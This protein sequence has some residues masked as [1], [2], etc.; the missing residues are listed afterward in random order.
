MFKNV[1]WPKALSITSLISMVVT[2]VVNFI[3]QKVS[4][5]NE[6]EMIH[7]IADETA[8]KVVEEMKSVD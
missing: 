5:Q 2:Y 6:V 7:R 8:K 1:N 3:T 4:Q